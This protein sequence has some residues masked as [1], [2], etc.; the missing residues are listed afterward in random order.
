M[1]GQNQVVQV[2]SK[3]ITDKL[4]TNI[5]KQSAIGKCILFQGKE[6]FVC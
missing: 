4:L 5:F 6:I 2:C 3:Y 1:Y